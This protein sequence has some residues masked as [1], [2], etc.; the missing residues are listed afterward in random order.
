M[1]TALPNFPEFDVSEQSTQAT[2]WKKWLSRFNNLV[3]AMDV[4]DEKR[5]KALLLHYA[6]EAVNEI[7]DTLPGTTA[8]GEESPFDKAVQALTSYFTP[9][10]NREYEIYVFRQA[11]QEAGETITAFHTR[12]RQ[13]ALTCDFGDV[14]RE[15]KTQIVQNCSSHKLRM[16]ALEKPTLTL[17]ELLD[18][19]KAMELSKSQAEIIEDK[20]VNKL[21][22]RNSRNTKKT[23]WRI[24]EPTPS[25]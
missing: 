6:G 16:K 1:A 23:R 12:L 9:R 20:S 22:R 14:E 3:V 11:K 10:E 5:K 15:I 4:G 18:T 7:F 17:T 2:R 24:S 21:S 13:L 8:T 19:G 25:V